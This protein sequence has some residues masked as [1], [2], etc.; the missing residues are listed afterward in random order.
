MLFIEQ[1]RTSG[2]RVN[3]QDTNQP[4]PALGI[5][6]SES[7]EAITDHKCEELA[8]NAKE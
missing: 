3:G 8:G 5:L 6:E 1:K 7:S 4:V 2:R